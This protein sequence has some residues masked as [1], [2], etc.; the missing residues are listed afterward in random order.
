MELIDT[1]PVHRQEYFTNV[2]NDVCNFI[3]G[4]DSLFL[5][6]MVSK[7]SA[8]DCDLDNLRPDD[9]Y[10]FVCECYL[11]KKAN[12]KKVNELTKFVSELMNK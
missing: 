4:Q 10:R 1:V 12:P 7:I 8:F 3:A 9:I 5:L 11:K 6:G 2:F